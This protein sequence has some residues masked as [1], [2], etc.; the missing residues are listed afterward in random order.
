MPLI[1]RTTL[2]SN[3]T[4]HD[5]FTAASLQGISREERTVKSL[6]CCVYVLLVLP[7]AGMHYEQPY[8]V[9][10][11]CHPYSGPCSY[12]F[13]KRVCFSLNSDSPSCFEFTRNTFR[14]QTLHE[15]HFDLQVDHHILFVG[16]FFAPGYSSVTI[17]V[18]RGDP[19]RTIFA[20]RKQA[21]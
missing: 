13:V 15:I 14:I 18:F 19:T 17:A 2:I 1:S 10:T 7:L 9:R 6:I 12:R 21:A 8:T 4:H 20:S 16:D 5:H 11:L 3:T